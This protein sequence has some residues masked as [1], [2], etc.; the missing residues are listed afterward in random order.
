MGRQGAKRRELGPIGGPLRA[1]QRETGIDR[2][3]LS[4]EVKAGRLRG[5]RIGRKIFV[6]RAAFAEWLRAREIRPSTH[7]ARTVD[8]VCRRTS[9]QK[10]RRSTLF[11]NGRG[12]AQT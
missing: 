11:K 5:S 10:Q 4:E 9:V 6:T 7:A 2:R 8:H 1:W 3:F 12:E